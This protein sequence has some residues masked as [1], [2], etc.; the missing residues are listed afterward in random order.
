MEDNTQHYRNHVCE[1]ET[2]HLECPAGYVISIQSA[3]YGRLD[4]NICNDNPW[5]T[6]T[7]SCAS[8]ERSL[9]I[10][11]ANC[12]EHTSCDIAATFNVFGNPCG[13]V[14]KYLE[15]THECVGKNNDFQENGG[16]IL[17]CVMYVLARAQLNMVK[18]ATLSRLLEGRRQKRCGWSKHRNV[19][20][21]I[22]LQ[23]SGLSSVLRWPNRSHFDG[24]LRN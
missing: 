5:N 21:N 24:P 4:R 2:L 3:N 7:D 11:R 22:G 18:S 10:A 13:D 17:N 12:D 1:H 23:L 14:F 19:K 16:M 6:D 9:A 8:L 15:V 20:P